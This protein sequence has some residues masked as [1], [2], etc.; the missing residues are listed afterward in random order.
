MDVK[1]GKYNLRMDSEASVSILGDS[2]IQPITNLDS[3]EGW[4]FK[5][6]VADT[7]F[8]LFYYNGINENLK[9][10]DMRGL[11]SRVLL[12]DISDVPYFSIYTKPTGQNDAQPWY[13]S[14]INWEIDMSK[15][16][17][18]NAEQII[19][20]CKQK[21]EFTSDVRPVELTKRTTD[22]V[23]AD[24]EEILFITLSSTTVGVVGQSDMIIQNVGYQTQELDI[25][26]SVVNRNWVLL[27]PDA[28]AFR[29]KILSDN[30]SL[31]AG[32]IYLS[33]TQTKYNNK[34]ISFILECEQEF[35]LGVLEIT[36][37]VSNDNI[38][39]IPL[40]PAALHTRTLGQNKTVSVKDTNAKYFK[41]QVENT[42][43][44]LEK[45]KSLSY[46]Y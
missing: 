10:N 38:E 18:T 31:D 28:N 9:V 39:Y 20:W 17:L 26:D 21:P 6:T 33:P 32:E 34:M 35:G 25:D 5:K 42:H 22:G 19:L 2:T 7:K 44:T 37:L 8:N 29:T 3:N 13:H 46:S 45:L 4:E 15:V 41:V 30:V 36:I 14:R 11:F 23:G 24:D 12:N 40:I 1:N 43:E 27:D 16:Y